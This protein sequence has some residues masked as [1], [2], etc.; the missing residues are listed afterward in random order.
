MKYAINLYFDKDTEENLSRLANSVAD[1]ADSEKISGYD[2]RPHLTVACFN[3][4]DEPQCIRLLQ[5]F[6]ES[7]KV[8]S[9]KIGSVG[10]FPDSRTIFA[11]PTLTAGIFRLQRELHEIMKDFDKTGWTH[12][13]PDNWSPHCTLAYTIEEGNETFLKAS[14]ILLRKFHPMTGEFAGLGLVNITP[15]AREVFETELSR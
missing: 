14:G 7:H 12:Y 3:D 6:A 8:I 1:E 10:M 15:P 11:T 13:C 5:S 2:I 4:V 9:L